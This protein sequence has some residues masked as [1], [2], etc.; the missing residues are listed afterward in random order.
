MLLIQAHA[1]IQQGGKPIGFPGPFLLRQV[2]GSTYAPTRPS[3]KAEE[4]QGDGG[5]VEINTHNV[6]PQKRARGQDVRDSEG[7]AVPGWD[8]PQGSQIW[9]LLVYQRRNAE[10]MGSR[11]GSRGVFDEEAAHRID[12]TAP[13]QQGEATKHFEMPH[14]FEFKHHCKTSETRNK[15][16]VTCPVVVDEIVYNNWTGDTF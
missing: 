15:V 7:K 3:G 13:Q 1:G 5:L 8:P 4:L 9:N 10:R 12:N 2:M 11:L 16:N 6:P 14:K